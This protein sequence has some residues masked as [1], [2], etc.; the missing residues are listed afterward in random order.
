MLLSLSEFLA[1]RHHLPVVDVRSEAEYAQGHIRQAVNVPLLNN[2]E[3]HRVGTTYKQLGQHAAIR[4]GFRLVGPRLDGILGQAEEISQGREM[5]I[6]CWRG[7]MR[8]SNFAQFVGMAGMRSRV[9]QGGYKTYR[10]AALQAFQTRLPLVLLTGFTGSGKTEIL[11]ALREAGEQVIDLEGLAH[12]RGS[13]FGGLFMPPQPTT[14]QFQNELFEEILKVDTSRPV[15]VEDESIAIGKIFLPP[16]FWQQMTLAPIVQVEVSLEARVAR[17]VRDYGQAPKEEFGE[18]M[19]KIRKKLGGQYLKAAEERL[20][21]DDMTTV[22]E[23][24]LTYYDKA[25]RQ[26]IEKRKDRLR[27]SITWSGD[28]ASTLARELRSRPIL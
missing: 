27:A 10:Q 22:M 7:G 1:L 23:I 21:A 9:L 17:L 13:A 20:L 15:W 3:R 18:I 28:E 14:E 11:R 8:S 4:E 12:H 24:L 6:H 5:L 25:Y 16:D 26:S 2:D 19:K